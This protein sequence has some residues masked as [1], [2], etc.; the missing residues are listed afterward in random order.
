MDVRLINVRTLVPNS[1]H[2]TNCLFAYLPIA[3]CKHTRICKTNPKLVSSYMYEPSFQ[4]TVGHYLNVS[5]NYASMVQV[6]LHNI[7]EPSLV[8]NRDTKLLSCAPY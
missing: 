8:I 6:L 3:F 2:M 7:A 1:S 4:P 5:G